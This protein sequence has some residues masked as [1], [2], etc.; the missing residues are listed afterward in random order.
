VALAA[1]T[2]LSAGCSDEDGPGPPPGQ[3]GNQNRG[4]PGHH[5]V[6]G[7]FKCSKRYTRAECLRIY[8]PP[9]PSGGPD[10][11]P[12]R[13][14]NDPESCSLEV[15]LYCRYGAESLRQQADCE[16]AVTWDQVKQS[17]TNAARYARLELTEC[18]ADAGPLC[19]PL[20]QAPP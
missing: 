13:N 18:L 12:C 10:Q 8:A 1:L 16:D 11:D 15:E 4:G 9:K 6:Y 3:P 17:G 14:T 19:R 2:F 7:G 20:E 5:I